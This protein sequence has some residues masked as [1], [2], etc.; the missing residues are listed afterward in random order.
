MKFYAAKN[1]NI[2]PS[3]ISNNCRGLTKK[4]NGFIWSY[5]EIIEQN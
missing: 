5:Y 3:A 1:L 2:S 4:S